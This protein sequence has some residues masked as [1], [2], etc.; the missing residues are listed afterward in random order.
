MVVPSNIYHSLAQ[1][2]SDTIASLFELLETSP[3]G[4]TENEAEQRQQDFGLNQLPPS[5]PSSVIGRFFRQF[6][7]ALV[8]MLIVAAVV[9]WQLGHSVDT[10]VICFVVLANAFIGVI[11]EG[12]A[13][14]ALRAIETLL[15][16]Q[17]TVYRDGVRTV[18]NAKNLVPGDIVTVEAGDRIPADIRW[19]ET[20]NLIVQEAILTGES[21]PVRK[22]DLPCPTNADLGDRVSIGFSGTIAMTGQGRGIVISTGNTTEIGKISKLV[23]QAD[24]TE[25]PLILQLNAFA[26]W[27]TLLILICGAALLNFT[28][29]IRKKEFSDALMSVIGLTV[30]AI[31]EGL[32][33]IMTIT[34]AVGVRAM[35]SKNAIIRRLPS[36]ETL[37]SVSIIC[38]DK[39]G[40]LTRNEMVVTDVYADQTSYTVSGT[41]YA[42]IGTISSGEDV[43][44]DTRLHDLAYA[45]LLC[46]DASLNSQNGN[47]TVAGDPME[48]ALLAL[49]EKILDDTKHARSAAVRQDTLPFDA[50]HR[51]MATRYFVN[52]RPVT[53]AKGAPEAILHLCDDTADKIQIHK[54]V[55]D[56]ANA[57]K[58]V[59]A[60]AL[61]VGEDHLPLTPEGLL[62]RLTFSGLAG[63]VDPPRPEAIC[64]VTECRS[65]GIG[66]KMIT[67]DHRD[68][69]ATIARQIGIKNPDNVMTG[70]DLDLVSDVELADLVSDTFVFARTSP[71]HKLRLVRA[72][73]N[74]NMVVAMTGDGVNDA[75]ALQQADVG[76]AMG[77]SGSDAAKDASDVIL[78]D[79][80]FV[81]IVAAVKEGR[82]VYHNIKTLVH[83]TLPTGGGE[84]SIVILA[85]L[86]GTTSPITPIQILW[87]NL[88][89]ELT[90]GLAIALEPIEPETMNKPPRARDA[91][92]LD[93]ALVWDIIVATSLFAATVF[94]V[95]SFTID[96]SGSLPLARTVAFNTLVTLQVIYLFVVRFRHSPSTTLIG[97]RGTPAV[98]IAITIIAVAQLTIT[99]LPQ[100]QMIFGTTALSPIYIGIILGSGLLVFAL[101]EV[102][103]Q[104]RNTIHPNGK[105]HTIGESH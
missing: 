40:T 16:Q 67:G 73:Q 87:V 45:A 101:L 65:A 51:I 83:W 39:T 100:A 58:R 59:I 49:S 5:Q 72:L 54:K 75:P 88:I 26:K 71:E 8:Y 92:L 63:L 89:C 11:Q 82:R 6:N 20:N 4:L 35:A 9:T 81:S 78:A 47:W 15:S 98:W 18:L 46:N 102:E 14:N 68:T 55:S 27:L 105:R 66:V 13:E 86:L 99:Y 31:P 62:G 12:R 57:G 43:V 29:F 69:A 33:A 42:P 97:L 30:A 2:H 52:G 85:L 22:S 96:T 25:T 93:T 1:A 28:V 37:G 103:K 70:S 21:Q 95:F 104:L 64:A 32:P 79:D 56:L 80:S 76:I 61:Y 48:G 23:A 19:I 10:A 77:K 24:K 36:L 17:A 38:T 84:A 34:M 7:N 44:T 53:Y 94:A 60:F 91:P 41:G 50:R 3:S 90:L 74:Q